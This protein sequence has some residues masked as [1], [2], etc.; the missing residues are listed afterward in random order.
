MTFQVKQIHSDFLGKTG[1]VV[2]AVGGGSSFGSTLGGA[3]NGAAGQYVGIRLSAEDV[4]MRGKSLT[5]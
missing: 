3:G 4:R 2:G 5:R 1:P